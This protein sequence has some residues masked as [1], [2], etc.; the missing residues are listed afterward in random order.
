MSTRRHGVAADRDRDRATRTVGRG[1]LGPNRRAGSSARSFAKCSFGDPHRISGIPTEGSARNDSGNTQGSKAL[2][3]RRAQSA[4]LANSI[5]FGAGC[6]IHGR[7]GTTIDAM[8]WPCSILPLVISSVL[9]IVQVLPW[10]RGSVCS[11]AEYDG[12]VL[13]MLRLA[14]PPRPQ[15]LHAPVDRSA[16]AGA[17]YR[18]L[19]LGRAAAQGRELFRA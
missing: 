2:C 8:I 19:A 10:V 5:I 7:F 14:N 11:P 15:P 4:D 9:S 1:R 13:S 16:L 18:S 17:D 12:I 3:I 6:A